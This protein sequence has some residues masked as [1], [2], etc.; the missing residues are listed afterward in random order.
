MDS[1]GDDRAVSTVV[2]AVLIFGIVVTLVATYQSQVVPNQNRAAEFEHSNAVQNDMVE[3]RNAILTA[4]TSGDKTFATVTLGTRYPN[5]ILAV[6]PPPPAGTLR[7]GAPRPITVSADGSPTNLCPSGGA[8]QSRTLR[9]RPGY[10]V[11]QGAPV[12]TYE[13][14]VLYL[15]FGD[16]QIPLTDQDLVRDGG[17][18][19]DIVPLNTSL[20][21]EGINAASIEPV[22]GAVREQELTDASVTLP[23]N[24]SES[25]WEEL[26]AGDLPAANVT[27]TD[28]NLTLQTGGDIQFSC[29]PV[30]LNKVPAGGQRSD[31]T[32]GTG[33]G[34]GMLNPSEIA[35]RDV[36]RSGGT[37]TA[38]FN[39]SAQ[40]DATFTAARMPFV[41]VSKSN[42]DANTVDPYDIINANTSQTAK[43]GLE[44]GGPLTPL[45]TDIQLPGNGT[46]TDIS[47]SFQNGGNQEFNQGGFLVVTV[48]LANGEFNTYLIEIPS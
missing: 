37:V 40:Q 7:T 43:S 36:T 11:Y 41:F 44:I 8:I 13:N 42:V 9:F 16:E 21:R 15:D 10:N 39:N 6:N 3:L 18:A 29:S 20:D 33:S 25:R 48:E 12:L 17:D 38:Q 24:L 19:V 4:K 2:G 35:L 31:G 26:L 23:T 47:F 14:T 34:T 27:V 45:D 22:P 5:R 1:R 46:R 32:A 28:G 30:G